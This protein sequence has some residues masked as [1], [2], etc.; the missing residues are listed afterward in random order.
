[1]RW[2]IK[3]LESHFHNVLSPSSKAEY[4]YL[5]GQVD[6]PTKELRIMIADTSLC[7]LIQIEKSLNK[8]GYYRVLPTQSCEDF[9]MLNSTCGIVFDVLIANK[10]LAL[11][12]ESDSTVFFQAAN[13]VNHALFYGSQPIELTALSFTS[14]KTFVTQ[15]INIPGDKLIEAFMSS[16]DTP[17]PPG[18]FNDPD[19]VKDAGKITHQRP[20]LKDN[21]IRQPPAG[22]P[23]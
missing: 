5:P 11:G 17:S 23:L 4:Q 19:R 3:V 1:M 10:E 2:L 15:A 22:T 21:D 16:I 6:M 9:W 8:A 14:A 7:R 18:C 20:A 12:T 13:N